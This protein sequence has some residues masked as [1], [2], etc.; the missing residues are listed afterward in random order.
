MLPWNIWYDFIVHQ[1]HWL[2][3]A[4]RAVKFFC[5]MVYVYCCYLNARIF[6][7]AWNGHDDVVSPS[8]A[9]L[10]TTLASDLDAYLSGSLLDTHAQPYY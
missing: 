8:A 10:V 6:S 4:F 5:H 3:N 2:S 7:W 1:V 9:D